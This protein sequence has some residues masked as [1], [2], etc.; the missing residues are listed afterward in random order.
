[1]HKHSTLTLQSPLFLS[2]AEGEE[3]ETDE[4]NLAAWV[5]VFQQPHYW[6]AELGPALLIG[7]STTRYRSNKYR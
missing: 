1:M 4:Q 5:D 3:F 7:L 2:C 6:T